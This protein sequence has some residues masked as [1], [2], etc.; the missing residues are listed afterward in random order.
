MG[1]F[2]ESAQQ[3]LIARVPLIE[4]GHGE[5]L[6]IPALRRLRTH[7]TQNIISHF[8]LAVTPSSPRTASTT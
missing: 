1:V 8:M 6:N 3:C 2:P 5:Y 4:T 7:E